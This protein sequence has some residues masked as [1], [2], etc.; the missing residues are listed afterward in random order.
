MR[1]P[2]GFSGSKHLIMRWFAF[3]L[4]PHPSPDIPGHNFSSEDRPRSALKWKLPSQIPSV[5]PFSGQFQRPCM[6]IVPTSRPWP[7]CWPI[8]VSS[9]FGIT[10]VQ[11]YTYYH[12]FPK[13]W[14][15]QKYAVC[16][17]NLVHI[18]TTLIPTLRSQVALLLYYLKLILFY[19]WPTIDY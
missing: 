13:D 14:Q 9:L 16:L 6:F 2:W 18:S 4:D 10:V 19:I 3:R 8:S 12:N 11:V 7:V 5:Q 15:F 17:Y 1:L